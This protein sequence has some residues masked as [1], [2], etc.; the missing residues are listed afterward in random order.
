VTNDAS[1]RHRTALPRN[2]ARDG[3]RAV[4]LPD[5]ITVPPNTNKDNH[6]V[7]VLSPSS[8]S[9][10]PAYSNIPILSAVEH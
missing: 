9:T 2:P 5:V 3:G 6:P 10:P 1:V 4:L 8:R 7:V